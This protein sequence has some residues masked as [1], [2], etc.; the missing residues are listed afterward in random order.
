MGK[1]F[2]KLAIK[3]RNHKEKTARVDILKLISAGH[4]TMPLP[5][6]DTTSTPDTNVSGNKMLFLLKELTDKEKV[7]WPKESLQ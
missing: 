3:G 1:S 6:P 4:G 7:E 5:A 2:L